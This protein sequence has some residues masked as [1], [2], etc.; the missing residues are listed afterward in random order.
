MARAEQ[1]T[2]DNVIKICHRNRQ[3]TQNNISEKTSCSQKLYG[4]D[5]DKKFAYKLLQR[6]K[7]DFHGIRCQKKPDE[8]ETIAVRNHD[9]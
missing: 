5:E 2:I 9:L 4:L 1:S 6:R 7:S 3:E 8:I